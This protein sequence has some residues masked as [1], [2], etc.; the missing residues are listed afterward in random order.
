M[1]RKKFKKIAW[2]VQLKLKKWKKK[3]EKTKKKKVALFMW[4]VQWIV[5]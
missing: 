3:R 4:T 2:V 1:N 5:K